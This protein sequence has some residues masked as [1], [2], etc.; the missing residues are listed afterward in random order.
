[1]NTSNSNVTGYL[2][3]LVYSAFYLLFEQ[4]RVEVYHNSV[5]DHTLQ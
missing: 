5:P 1:M 3:N 2:K 4:A